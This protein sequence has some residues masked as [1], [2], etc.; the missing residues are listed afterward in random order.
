M[1]GRDVPAPDPEGFTWIMQS[2]SQRIDPQLTLAD[3]ASLGTRLNL[4]ASWSYANVTLESDFT[5][6]GYEVYV[7]VD[8]FDNAY[9][10][11]HH[12]ECETCAPAPYSSSGGSAPGTSAAIT[13]LTA[14][15]GL[16]ALR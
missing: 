15:A 2:Y 1:A 10:R 3:L 4:P 16:A 9:T 12:P 14:T 11:M 7:A 13:L 5:F 6:A 8:D